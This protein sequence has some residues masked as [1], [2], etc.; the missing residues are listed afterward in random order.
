MRVEKGKH[1]NA[2]F[3]NPFVLLAKKGNL[4]NLLNQFHKNLGDFS[5]CRNFTLKVKA[6]FT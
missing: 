5:V 4:T 2:F 6:C 3:L 1:K